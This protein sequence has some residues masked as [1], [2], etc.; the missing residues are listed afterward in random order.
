M[1]TSE[2]KP[3]EKVNGVLI[4]Y[5]QNKLNFFFFE[6]FLIILRK[7]NISMSRKKFLNFLNYFIKI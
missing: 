1:S 5:A 3:K 6:Y 7:K 2:N 4:E